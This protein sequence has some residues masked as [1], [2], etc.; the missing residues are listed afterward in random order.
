[1]PEPLL[2]ALDARAAAAGVSRAEA[3]RTILEAAL[4]TTGDGVDRA[5]IEARLAMSPAERVRTMAESARRLMVLQG[6]AAA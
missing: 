4:L 2:E 3:V 1:M 6:R 5:Q